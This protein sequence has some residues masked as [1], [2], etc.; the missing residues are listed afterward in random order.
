MRKGGKRWETVGK[1]EKILGRGASG[2]FLRFFPTFPTLPLK[3]GNRENWKPKNYPILFE[4]YF[5]SLIDCLLY[6]IY[7]TKIKIPELNKKV[8]RGERKR[9]SDENETLV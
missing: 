7:T 6:I 5:V 1:S 8:W 9:D 4:C 2:I 3:V